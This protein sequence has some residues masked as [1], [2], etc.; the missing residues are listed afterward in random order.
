VRAV[1]TRVRSASVD[2][3]DARIA[4][5][6]MGLLVLL[7]VAREDAESDAEA[8]AKKIVDLRIFRDDAGTMNRSLAVVAGELLVVS[9][10]TL[11]GDARH[12]RRP[13]FI[14]AAPPE[15]GR[16]LYERFVDAVRRL[17]PHVE[18]G[19]FGAMMEVASVNDGPVTILLDTTRLF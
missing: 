15:L 9:Q 14:N 10:F 6:G 19:A 1:V 17:G 18:T 3:D 16:A 8:L 5:I 13:S 7:G 11:L 4:S 2:V 12:G